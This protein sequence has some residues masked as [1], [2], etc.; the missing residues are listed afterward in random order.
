VVTLLHEAFAILLYE[1]YIEKLI[2]HQMERQGEKPYGKAKGKYQIIVC[3]EGGVQK[4][5]RDS[6]HCVQLLTRIERAQMP[7]KLKTQCCFE[8]PQV[9]R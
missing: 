6:M 5:S 7:R 2:A 3:M 9:W 4:V 1:K 8:A